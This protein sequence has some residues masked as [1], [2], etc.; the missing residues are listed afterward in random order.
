MNALARIVLG[1]LVAACGGD[2]APKLPA[3]DKTLRFVHA[4]VVGILRGDSRYLSIQG[5]ALTID[6][7]SCDDV[8]YPSFWDDLRQFA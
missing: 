6:D 3:W 4:K 7:P 1:G 2:A 5:N 8:S